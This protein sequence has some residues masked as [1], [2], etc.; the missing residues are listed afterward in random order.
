[1]MPS[2]I[3]SLL[4][5]EVLLSCSSL[6]AH[7][8]WVQVNTQLVRV[9]D[10]AHIDLC[11]GNHGNNH[12]DFRLASKIDLE[13]CRLMLHAPQGKTFDLMSDLVDVGYAPKEGFYS[14][15][16]TTAAPGLHLV[17]HTVDKIVN[18]G[19]PSRSI[20]S[21]KTFFVSSLSLDKV[22]EDQPGFDKV[23]GHP[24]EL[25]P[26]KNPVLPMGPE[27]AIKV[28]LLLKGQPFPGQVVSFI[29]RS[30][31]LKEGF[32]EEYERKTDGQGV[33][34]FTPKF[35]DYYLIVAHHT[36][37]TEKTEQYV[38]TGYSAT[39]TLYVPELCPCCD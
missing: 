20:K 33:V 18:H 17:E 12:R 31:K 30:A 1:M 2:R 34:T 16:Y 8:T 14:A 29:P 19:Q 15:R 26:V 32:D 36:D 27:E 9:A 22:S 13:G 21:A 28:K 5:L 4:L 39:L 35:G 3:L 7:D 38:K 10:N 25:V 24:L 23:L 37:T 11:L 6:F